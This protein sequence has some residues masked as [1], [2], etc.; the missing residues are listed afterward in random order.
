MDVAVQIDGRVRAHLQLPADAP[1]AEAERA[2]L[3][4]PR[5]QEWLRGRRVVRSVLVAS[6]LLSLV[7]ER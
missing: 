4:H 6:K 7:M 1:Q 5:V 2:A 3:A